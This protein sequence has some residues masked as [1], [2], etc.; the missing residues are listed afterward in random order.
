ME[1]RSADVEGQLDNADT[2][3]R[4][5]RPIGSPDS[6]SRF[7]R[8]LRQH[9]AVATRVAGIHRPRDAYYVKH[10]YEGERFVAWTNRAEEGDLR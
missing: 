7:G 9:N 1:Q 5:A 8:E 4:N 10:Q 3:D 2:I 6:D